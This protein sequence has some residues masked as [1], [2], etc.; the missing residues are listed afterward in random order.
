M[1]RKFNIILTESQLGQLF[2][3]ALYGDKSDQSSSVPTDSDGENYTYQKN[4]PVD[5]FREVNLN[6]SK[7]YNAYKNAAD[8]FIKT[9]S[10]NLL[11]ITGDMLATAAKNAYNT[12]K[13]FVP[14]ELS[15]A[16]LA[17]EGGFSN[18]KNSRPIKTKNP[19]NVGNVD[20]GANVK[21]GSVQDG[22]QRYYNLVAKDYLS[23]NRKAGDLI[24]HYVNKNGLRYA[25][26]K[27][28]ESMLKDL[29]AKAKQL[30]EPIYAT[31]LNNI[32]SNQV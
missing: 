15:V 29:S 25:S 31:A 28:Y 14:V 2:F 32:K 7:G 12:Y 16:Q 30:S 20:S 21:Y 26:S 13:N 24:N 6:T 22:I 4:L 18:N 17:A 11:N 27:N 10:S 23:N 9:R 5:E 1:R 3:D 8:A 19:Y